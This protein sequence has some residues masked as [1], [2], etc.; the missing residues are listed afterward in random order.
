MFGLAA[1]LHRNTKHVSVH[2][3]DKYM[4]NVLVL[5]TL[6]HI[7]IFEIRDPLGYACDS[8]E[9]SQDFKMRKQHTTTNDFRLHVNIT[10]YWKRTKRTGII[11]NLTFQS[12]LP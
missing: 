11:L 2:E 4:K 9:I 5:Y 7:F 8:N 3:P 12:N 1:S 6:C 10:S